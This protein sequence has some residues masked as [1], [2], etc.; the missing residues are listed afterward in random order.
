ME[1]ITKMVL[2]DREREFNHVGTLWANGIKTPDGIIYAIERNIAGYEEYCKNYFLRG[3]MAR[4]I[5]H[6]SFMER[7]RELGVDVS[8][9][10][11]ELKSSEQQR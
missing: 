1:D 3:V 4:R 11:R 5:F 6:R 9:Y 8:K 2:G 10:P 7:A